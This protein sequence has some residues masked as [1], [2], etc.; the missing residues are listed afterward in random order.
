ML[1]GDGGG[2]IR[3][4]YDPDVIFQLD[5]YHIQQEI[6]RK[7]KDKDAQ[8]AIREYLNENKPDEMLAYIKAYADSVS[9][10]D[11]KDKT[12]SNAMK[13][14]EYLNNN[15]EGLLPYQNR[16]IG[17]PEPPKGVVYKNMGV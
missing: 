10:N 13:L 2:W 15:R 12:S 17:I 7:I 3:D 16:G 9:S 5:R 4:P 11:E 14:Y 8:A 1:N 6:L